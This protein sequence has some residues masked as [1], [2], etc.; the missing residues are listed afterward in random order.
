MLLAS[1]LPPISHEVMARLKTVF[2]GP[3]VEKNSTIEQ[4]KWDAAQKEVVDFLEREYGGN[5]TIPEQKP[6][7]EV[8]QKPLPLWKRVVNY[9]RGGLNG[10]GWRWR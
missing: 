1:K 6:E 2:P 10:S 8:T 4:V 7:A 9:I 3:R 5:Q